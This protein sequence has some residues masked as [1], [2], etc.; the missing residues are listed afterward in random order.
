MQS[1]PAVEQ[2]NRTGRSVAYLAIRLVALVAFGYW[3][4]LSG[5]AT[6]NFLTPQHT[7]RGV[8]GPWPAAAALAA[9]DVVVSAVAFYRV[10]RSRTLR[11]GLA[12]LVGGGIIAVALGFL[13]VIAPA[14]D[15]LE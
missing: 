7:V 3:A 5:F 8:Y 6:V 9:V 1:R 11:N 2:T 15:A 10:L 12:W 13:A 4:L 14:R